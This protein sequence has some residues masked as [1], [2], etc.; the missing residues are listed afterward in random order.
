MQHHP[1]AARA[2]LHDYSLSILLLAGGVAALSWAVPVQGPLLGSVLL[3]M[4][5]VLRLHRQRRELQSRLAD[6]AVRDEDTGLLNRNGF[7][8]RADHLLAMH[9]RSDLPLVAICARVRAGESGSASPEALR[10][11]AGIVGRR[12]RVT[13]LLGRVR[14]DELALLLVDADGAQADRVMARVAEEFRAWAA[15][16]APGCELEIGLVPVMAQHWRC[17]QLLRRGE[18][19]LDRPRS[20]APLAASLSAG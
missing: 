8:E 6:L 20:R 4:L 14:E 13:D 18:Q 9:Q 10:A 5:L 2:R 12:L 16:G 7:S 17:D 3:L 19:V 1:G 15:R 11:L